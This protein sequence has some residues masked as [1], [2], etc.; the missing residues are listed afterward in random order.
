MMISLIWSLATER[1]APP[2][3]PVNG[4]CEPCGLTRGEI[5]ALRAVVAD[6]MDRD[7][8]HPP[9]SPSKNV[10]E[11]CRSCRKS[12]IHRPGTTMK[13]TGVA[14]RQLAYLVSSP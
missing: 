2:Q 8:Q 3:D 4:V 1:V 11:D 12:G 13:P 10:L 14:E 9:Q 6:A 7:D 5:D